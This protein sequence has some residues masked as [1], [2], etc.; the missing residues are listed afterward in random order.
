MIYKE[1]RNIPKYGLQKVPQCL[2]QTVPCD[3]IYPSNVMH[4]KNHA[5]KKNL[6][7]SDLSHFFSIFYLCFLIDHVQIICYYVIVYVYTLSGIWKPSFFWRSIRI[8][9]ERQSEVSDKKNKKLTSY[10]FSYRYITLPFYQEQSLL[11][12]LQLPPQQQPQQAKKEKKK[13]EKR[14]CVS[15]KVSICNLKQFF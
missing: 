15:T 10:L 1:T 4:L 14:N 11:M 6:S 5:K 7:N 13:K 8:L 3:R 12:D 2:G 9:I